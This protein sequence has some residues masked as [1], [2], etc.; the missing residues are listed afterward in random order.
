M[1]KKF[2]QKYFCVALAIRAHY[3][4]QL[5]RGTYIY[6]KA[7]MVL[8]KTMKTQPSKSFPVYGTC[9]K[10]LSIANT[11]CATIAGTWPDFY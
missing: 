1:Y 2:S 9:I 10:S 11:N 4:V 3:L 6:G 7:S 8:L 5:K